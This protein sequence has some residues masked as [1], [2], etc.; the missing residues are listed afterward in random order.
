[1]PKANHTDIEPKDIARMV[2]TGELEKAESIGLVMT[3]DINGRQRPGLVAVGVNGHK[4]IGVLEPDEGMS[5]AMAIAEAV[6][7]ADVGG[8]AVNGRQAEC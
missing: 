7:F 2:E 6:L 3:T 5:I 8:T 1:M 4:V